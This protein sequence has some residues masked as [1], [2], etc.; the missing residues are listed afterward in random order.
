MRDRL[1]RKSR[2]ASFSSKTVAPMLKML[3]NAS[4]AM[5]KAGPALEANK[6]GDAIEHQDD[7]LDALQA[8]MGFA[9]N[10]SNGWVGLANLLMTAEGVAVPARYMRDIA[11]EQRDLIAETKKSAPGGRPRTPNTTRRAVP[12][13]PR[14]SCT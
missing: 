10:E 2:K 4:A 5:V 6:L 14:P 8:A 3:E 12:T 11:A 1:A 13:S 7:A 9:N